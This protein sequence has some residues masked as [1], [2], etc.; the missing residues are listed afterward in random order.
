MTEENR[1]YR[2]DL[3]KRMYLYF[4]SFCEAGAPSFSKFARSAGLT[5]SELESFRDRA[6]FERAYRECNEIRRDYLI[7]GALTRRLDPS[8]VKFL[9]DSEEDPDGGDGSLTVRLEVV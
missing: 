6:E 5:L 9:L 4:C 2:E 1:V 3:P 8:F 7:D